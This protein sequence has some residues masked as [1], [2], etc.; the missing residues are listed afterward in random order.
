MGAKTSR[1]SYQMFII[2]VPCQYFIWRRTKA[3]FYRE[4]KT[5][6]N[7]NLYE[8]LKF[9]WKIMLFGSVL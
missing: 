4:N 6:Q 9:V 5:F 3:T 7:V 2:N 1:N 8:C